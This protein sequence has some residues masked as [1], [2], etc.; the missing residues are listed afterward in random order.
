MCTVESLELLRTFMERV[1]LVFKKSGNLKMNTV[2][3]CS[4][5]CVAL[6]WRLMPI[7]VCVHTVNMKLLDTI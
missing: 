4:N 5:C 1:K 7:S 6:T 2:L 3:L